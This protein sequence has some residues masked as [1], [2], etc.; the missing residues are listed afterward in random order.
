MI[1][2]GT[3]LFVVLLTLVFTLGKSA[4]GSTLYCES[5]DLP[6]EG[7]S[8]GVY[9]DR[10]D[11]VSPPAAPG[12]RPGVYDE[13]ETG[14]VEAPAPV[15]GTYGGHEEEEEGDGTDPGIY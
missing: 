8:P 4:T 14:E 5:M 9:Q 11:S 10:G 15:P 7:T 1:P 3:R 12:P 6:S 2:I 13:R